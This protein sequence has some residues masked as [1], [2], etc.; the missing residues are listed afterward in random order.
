MTATPAAATPA[1]DTVST[2]ANSPPRNTRSVASMVLQVA[3]IALGVFL[4]LAGEEWR[5]AQANRRVAA[6][7]MRRFHA[8]V[9]ANRD[10]LLRIKDYHTARLEE[11]NAHFAATPEEKEAAKVQL[12]GIR[13]PRFESTAWELAV[14]TGT[15]AHLEPELAFA[16]SRTYGFQRMTDLLGTGLANAMYL[17]P[18]PTEP[19][20]FLAAVQLYYQDLSG[21]EPGLITAYDTL[22]VALDEALGE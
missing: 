17:K 18:P 16:L 1:A 10:M 5:E 13:P 12:A 2:V 19:E 6:E 14:A 3:L 8:E 22:I 20:A 7:T 11:L 4:G 21:I 9:V 15:L